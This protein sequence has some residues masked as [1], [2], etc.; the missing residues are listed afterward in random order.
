MKQDGLIVCAFRYCLGRCSY[1]VSEMCDHLRDHWDEICPA[2]QDLIRKEI[3]DAI[4]RDA[5]GMDMDCK[6]WSQLIEDISDA[7]K[8]L[9]SNR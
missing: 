9:H 4:Q 8:N 7:E 5:C 1:V 3:A 2:Y 6:E